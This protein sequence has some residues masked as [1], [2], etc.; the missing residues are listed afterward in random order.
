MPFLTS[1][2]GWATQPTIIV[3]EN[4]LSNQEA[5]AKQM[6]S[7]SISGKDEA[8]FIGNNWKNNQQQGK[9]WRNNQQQGNSKKNNQNQHQGHNWKN[10]QQQGSNW[11]K[12]IQQQGGGSQGEIKKVY[13]CYRCGKSGHIKKYCR[14]V[15]VK[16]NVGAFKNG[17]G[18]PFGNREWNTCLSTEILDKRKMSREPVLTTTNAICKSIRGKDAIVTANNSIHLVKNEGT[19]KMNASNAGCVTLN[20]VYHV[21]DM[22]KNLVSVSQISNSGKYVLF[23]TDDVKVLSNI[24]N[25]EADIFVGRKEASYSGFYYMLVLVDDYTRFTWVYFMRAK[26]ETFVCFKRFKRIVEAEFQSRISTNPSYVDEQGKLRIFP[27]HDFHSSSHGCDLCPPNMCKGL[28]IE[29][30]QSSLAEE[31]N[32]KKKFIYLGDGC[33]DFCPSL[34]LK[35]GDYV[36]PRKNYPVWDLICKNMIQ[37]K[38]EIHEWSDGEDLERVLLRLINTISMEEENK[39][40]FSVDCKFETI[41]PVVAHDALPQALS[42][43]H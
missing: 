4:L 27:Y 9:N 5:L 41:I 1:I 21:P 38:A 3:L 31:G 14:T 22:T 17:S 36:M 20:S 43:P 30:M 23:G 2:Q 19:V 39:K 37:I 40:L 18:E 8:L 11:R 28:I 34:K 12:K 33:G 16:G 13:N 7:A 35:Q 32:K 6:A 15:M 42:V 26:S 25:M 24:R 10:N 29:K